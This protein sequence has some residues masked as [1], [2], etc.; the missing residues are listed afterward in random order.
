MINLREKLTL[1]VI[2]V[3]IINEE[4]FVIQRKDF[5]IIEIVA[6]IPT[7]IENLRVRLSNS[8]LDVCSIDGHQKVVKRDGLNLIEI[9]SDIIPIDKAVT[10]GATSTSDLSL[11]IRSTAATT[12]VNSQKCKT[13]AKTSAEPSASNRVNLLG[14]APDAPT[15]MANELRR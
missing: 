13:P 3:A 14:F 2:E 5:N 7:L 4:Q 10:S 12:T 8:S 15:F 11:L 1:G 9:L 6:I